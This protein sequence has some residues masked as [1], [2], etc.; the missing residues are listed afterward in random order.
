MLRY[1]LKS[2]RLVLLYDIRLQMVIRQCL[3]TTEDHTAATSFLT[4]T[5]IVHF[6][7]HKEG[8]MKTHGGVEV[9]IHSFFSRQWM[10]V[11]DLPS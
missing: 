5:C 9:Q 1:R 3:L 7:V 6:S 11:R 2:A 10:L 4:S 8:T